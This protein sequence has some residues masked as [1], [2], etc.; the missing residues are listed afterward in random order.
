MKIKLLTV[1]K[2]KEASFR[3][4]VAEYEKRLTRYCKLSITEVKD[5]KAPENLSVKEEDKIREIEG[6]K[7]LQKIDPEDYVIALAIN[8]KKYTSVSFSAHMEQVYSHAKG[9]VCFVIGGSLGLSRAVLDRSDEQ[10]SF[11]DMTF[12][13]Q[14]MR[15]IFLEQLYRAFRIASGEPYHK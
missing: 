14:L 1:G 15:V 9:S 4:A 2:I 12:P 11:S 3:D 6:E 10:L 7:L 5:E 13:H 8:G